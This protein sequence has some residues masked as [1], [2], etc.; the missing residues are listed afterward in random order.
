MTK[1]IRAS[2]LYLF[3]LLGVALAEGA[4]AETPAEDITA[5]CEFAGSSKNGA[6]RLYDRDY[7]TF[8]K[9][10]EERGASLEITLP[11]GR[12]AAYLYLSLIHI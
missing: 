7:T 3:L 12:E 5:Q 6:G 9:S 11:E 10:G 1:R 2:F 8:W 4:L